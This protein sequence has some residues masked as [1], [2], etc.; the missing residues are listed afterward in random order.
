MLLTRTLLFLNAQKGAK[1]KYN[2]KYIIVYI[3]LSIITLRL[4]L[5]T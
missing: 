4:T 1:G 5:T 2:P 3:K